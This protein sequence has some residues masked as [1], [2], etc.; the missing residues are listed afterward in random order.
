[1]SKCGIAFRLVPLDGRVISSATSVYMPSSL[2]C[3]MYGLI[4][5]LHN[6]VG[7]GGGQILSEKTLR[8]EGV[9]FNVISFTRG[10]V[11]VHFPEKSVK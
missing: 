1:M 4:R 9:W 7:G 3:A 10:W 2:L 5:V 11:G 8:Y 6:T